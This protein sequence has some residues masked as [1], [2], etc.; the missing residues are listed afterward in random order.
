MHSRKAAETLSDALCRGCPRIFA[1]RA[2]D[3]VLRRCNKADS[4][5]DAV[6][7]EDGRGK[8]VGI[9]AGADLVGH[10][11]KETLQ[12]HTFW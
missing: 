3:D 12:Y 4:S 2:Q 10:K 5:I 11:R 8:I 7:V 6:T 1:Y 9:I